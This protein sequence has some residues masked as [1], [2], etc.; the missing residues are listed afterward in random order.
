MSPLKHL[1]LKCLVLCA[2]LGLAACGG[3]SGE[4]PVIDDGLDQ[5]GDLEF[6]TGCDWREIFREG[7]QFHSLSDTA[8]RYWYA[9]AP[10]E[11][12]AVD[13]STPLDEDG[14]FNVV[15]STDEDRPANADVDN[16]FVWLNWKGDTEL[17]IYRMMLAADSFAQSIDQVDPED[18][19]ASV[20]GDC[21]PQTTYCDR[22]VFEASSGLSPA[23]VFAT[24]QASAS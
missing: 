7:E 8:A 16:G 23:E 13:P 6:S 12:D 20:M 14:F 3:D 17:L 1:P 24:C 11:P 5:F 10:T 9:L 22:D 19:P 21:F 15:V 2:S 18:D 4:E